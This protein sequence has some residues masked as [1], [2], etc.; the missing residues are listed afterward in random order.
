[1]KDFLSQ[2]SFQ[3]NAGIYIKDPQ[4]SALG[5]RLISGGINLLAEI[6]LEE[7]TFKKLSI[8]IGTTEASI[9]R[10]FES[11]HYLLL[12]LIAWYWGWLEY[13]LLFSIVNIPD[14]YLRLQIAIGILTEP[15]VEDSNFQYIN[16]IKLH[17]IIVSESSKV[18]L[19]KKVDVENK[20]GYFSGY[21][22]IVERVGSIITEIN[23]DYKY[24]HMLVSTVIEGAHHER[25]FAEHLPLLTD[26]HKGEDAI[27]EF[28]KDIVF[29]AI[30]P[31]C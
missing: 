24:P 17:H 6:G 19:T 12:Y 23:P 11:K 26:V 18:Y 20:E 13:R 9:Y 30:M 5:H 15:V 28:Y 1:M 16:E 31:A 8:A 10:Y 2:V 7:F 27:T 21:K 14:P 25:F 4:S 22:Q 3:I 29:K